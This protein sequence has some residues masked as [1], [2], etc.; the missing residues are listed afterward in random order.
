MSYR[1]VTLTFFLVVTFV[2]MFYSCSNQR[3]LA[4]STKYT[5][6]QD[7]IIIPKQYRPSALQA[8]RAETRALQKQLTP[9]QKQLQEDL[10]NVLVRSKKAFS[11]IT[12]IKGMLDYMNANSIAE[13]DLFLRRSIELRQLNDTLL[14]HQLA[15]NNN[16]NRLIGIV[17]QERD[18]RIANEKRTADDRKQ[19]VSNAKALNLYTGILMAFL[20][21]LLIIL[22]LVW[23]DVKRIKA[24]YKQ[25]LQYG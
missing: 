4:G 5:L 15:S 25:Q 17:L 9:L 3:S 10:P 8:S 12:D 23:L 7:T 16:I 24:K 19:N 11:E 21:T 13:R 2:G 20:L 1:K 6:I 18:A 14:R 22:L